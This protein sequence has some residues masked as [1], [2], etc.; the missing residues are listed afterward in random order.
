MDGI[1]EMVANKDISFI[2]MALEHGVFAM[3]ISLILGTQ[4]QIAGSALMLGLDLLRTLPDATPYAI[5]ENFIKFICL[6]PEFQHLS[7]SLK[8]KMVYIMGEILANGNT[9][10][11]NEILSNNGIDASIPLLPCLKREDLNVFGRGILRV[12]NGIGVNESLL[13][14][15]EVLCS[16]SMDEDLIH[17]LSEISER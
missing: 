4:I 9:T 12:S 6:P 17:S 13:S 7:F 2:T 14:A 10:C 16:I 3:L 8:T 15:I 1:S 5:Q 11:L